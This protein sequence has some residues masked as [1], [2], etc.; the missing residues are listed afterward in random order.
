MFF[1]CIQT[2]FKTTSILVRFIPSSREGDSNRRKTRIEGC[3]IGEKILRLLFIYFCLLISDEFVSE[4]LRSRQLHCYVCN[5]QYSLYE[6]QSLWTCN[7]EREK[8]R[9]NRVF[10]SMENRVN[11]RFSLFMA[12]HSSLRKRDLFF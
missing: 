4:P 9:V 11:S 7:T 8:I 1:R 6:Q 10:F 12:R 5:F 3:S 2:T